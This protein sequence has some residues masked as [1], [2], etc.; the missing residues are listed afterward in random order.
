MARCLR[1]RGEVRSESLFFVLVLGL[2]LV[3]ETADFPPELISNPSA[4]AARFRSH[5]R[6]SILGV[7]PYII[8]YEN[9]LH[10]TSCSVLSRRCP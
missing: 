9:A 3:L 7:S 2:V 4:E 10:Y 5:A 6:R 1:E 8:L